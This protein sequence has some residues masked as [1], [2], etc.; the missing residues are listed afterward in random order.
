MAN[1]TANTAHSAITVC[2]SMATT[3]FRGRSPAAKHRLRFYQTAGCLG[4]RHP[5]GKTS[6]AS[7]VA[8]SRT[9]YTLCTL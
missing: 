4:S 6:Y 2:T 1:T 7:T 8:D 3:P 5:G 9:W